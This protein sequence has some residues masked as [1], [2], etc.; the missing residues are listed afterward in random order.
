[1]NL[2]PKSE[3]VKI[4]GLKN[5]FKKKSQKDF[6]ERYAEKLL[7]GLKENMAKNFNPTEIVKK[8]SEDL[9]KNKELNPKRL[10]KIIKEKLREVESAVLAPVCQKLLIY[11]VHGWEAAFGPKPK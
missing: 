5:A 2:D 8:V 7:K 10:S 3:R 6:N 4:L 9:E 11:L 1:M